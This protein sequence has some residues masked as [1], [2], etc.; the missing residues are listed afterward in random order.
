MKETY[1]GAC[2]VG[3]TKVTVL[4]SSLSGKIIERLTESTLIQGGRFIRWKDGTAYYGISEQLIEMLR[5]A[6]ASARVDTLSGIGLVQQALS[7]MEQLGTL[8]T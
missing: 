6:M 1:L 3:G 2:D 5:H 7:K 4:I 8:P